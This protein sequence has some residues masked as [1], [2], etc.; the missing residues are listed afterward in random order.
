MVIKMYT[1]NDLLNDIKKTGLNPT[2]TVL[3]H[4]SFSSIKNISG[5]ANCVLEVL[6]DYFKDGLVLLP[7]HTWA[8]IQQD[9][10][11]MD[12][13]EPN[14]CVGYLTN[15]AILDKDFIRSNH[16]TH[17]VAAYGK[18]AKEFIKDDDFA[19]TPCDPKCSYGKLLNN[20]KI[21]FIGAKLS[22]NT[23]VHCVEEIANVP[24]RFTEHIYTFYTKTE[25][26]NL[27][28]FHM[29]RHFNAKC[30]H[31]SDNYEKLL[32]IMLEKNIAQ[33]V[34][35][36]DSNSYLVDAKGCK[37]LVLE[38]LEKDIHALDDERDVK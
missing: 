32:P 12:K 3:I 24:D 2:D 35:I 25:D 22:K 19:K 37:E 17:S 6:K 4:S 13:H 31:I 26:G 23:L 11:I 15:C 33:K 30:P 5:G 36:L 34:K 29:P 20:G 27:I 28:E 14:S 8:S 9:G 38:I 18:N 7:T 10:Q 21:L 16:P 1:Y